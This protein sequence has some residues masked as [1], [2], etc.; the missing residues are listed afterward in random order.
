[1]LLESVV[2]EILITYFHILHR[3]GTRTV[4]MDLT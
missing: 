1:M 4:Y 3:V 2:V